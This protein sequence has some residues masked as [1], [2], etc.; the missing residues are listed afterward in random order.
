MSNRAKIILIIVLAFITTM[1]A[2]SGCTVVTGIGYYLSSKKKEETSKND[3]RPSNNSSKSQKSSGDKS[4]SIATPILSDEEAKTLIEPLPPFIK[5]FHQK[6]NQDDFDGMYDLFNN[7]FKKELS[8]EE[9]TKFFS[10]IKDKFGNVQDLSNF[11]VNVEKP[12]SYVII[13]VSCKVQYTND[14]IS[15]V[16]SFIIVDD[17]VTL[18]GININAKTNQS[19]TRVENSQKSEEDYY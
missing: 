10:G 6:F 13:T 15:E 11:E 16:F 17:K 18:N 14:T 1:G 4:S 8:R 19:N 5:E 9:F 12:E 2:C 3:D 7:A